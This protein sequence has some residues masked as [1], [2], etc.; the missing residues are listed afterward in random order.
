[1]NCTGVCLPLGS[2]IGPEWTPLITAIATV[3]LGLWTY[4][5]KL[6]G[7]QRA[8]GA[9]NKDKR[10]KLNAILGATVSASDE[11]ASES[12]PILAPGKQ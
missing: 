2:P 12:T 11:D 6:P 10:D 1:M 3:L 5:L 8:L 9:E 7:V 4:M